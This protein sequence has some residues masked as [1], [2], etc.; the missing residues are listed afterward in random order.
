MRQINGDNGCISVDHAFIE[1]VALASPRSDASQARSTVL[2]ANRNQPGAS[3][4]KE[5]QSI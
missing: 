3:R 1:G 5:K 2:G 4:T